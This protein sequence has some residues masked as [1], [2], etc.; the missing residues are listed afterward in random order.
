MIIDREKGIV[1]MQNT[2][3]E[4]SEILKDV[5]IIVTEQGNMLGKIC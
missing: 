2:M 4:I 5:G 3:K 1:E